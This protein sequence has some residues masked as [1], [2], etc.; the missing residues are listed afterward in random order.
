MQYEVSVVSS[1]MK[2]RVH[3]KNSGFTLWMLPAD[4]IVKGDLTHFIEFLQFFDKGDNFCNF[5]FAFLH[6]KPFWKGV[7]SKRSEFASKGSKFFPFSEDPFSKGSI[8]QFDIA[9]PECLFISLSVKKV[10]L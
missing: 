7:Y 10:N 5:L 4:K 9:F 3:K 1:N 8:K 6:T 2:I